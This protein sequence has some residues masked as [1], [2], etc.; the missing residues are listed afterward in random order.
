MLLNGRKLANLVSAVDKSIY[1]DRTFSLASLINQMSNLSANN[2]AGNSIPYERYA[3]VDVG[4]VVIVNPAKVKVFVNN[5][6]SGTRAESSASLGKAANPS[7]SRSSAAPAPLAAPA[8]PLDAG[9][10]N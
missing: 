10:I 8:K 3:T 5:L 1:V 4:S 9:C 6:I 7:P 2:I